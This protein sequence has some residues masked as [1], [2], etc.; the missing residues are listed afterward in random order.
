[1]AATP[2]TAELERPGGRADV[3]IVRRLKTDR[4]SAI[5]GPSTDH[6]TAHYTLEGARPFRVRGVEVIAQAGTLVV[7][8]RDNV[9]P[10]AAPSPRATPRW[11]AMSVCFDTGPSRGWVP[12]AGF[13]RVATDIYRA[14]LPHAATR[15]RIRDAFARL[16]DDDQ[17][18]IASR[19]VG[20]IGRGKLA[21]A[22]AR[23]DALRRELMLLTLREI[24]LLAGGD[25]EGAARLDSRVRA[26]LETMSRDVT[27]RHTLESLGADSGLSRSRFGHLFRSELGMSPIHALRVMRLRQAA[28]ALQYTADPIERIAEVT[29]FTSLS[30]LSRE[31]RRHYGVSPRSYRATHGARIV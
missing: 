3:L 21:A 6:W 7:Y 11:D 13:E 31:F 22:P 27:A 19:A 28:L 25:R 2:R 23:D 8:R 26:A 30:H 12:L 16:A 5:H 18:R 24:L 29:G 17:A 10:P 9:P 20:T 14:A 1:M 15:Q 4:P